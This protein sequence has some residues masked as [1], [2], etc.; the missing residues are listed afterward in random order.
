MRGSGKNVYYHYYHYYQTHHHHHHHKR[1]CATSP[2]SIE[3]KGAARTAPCL[4]VTSNLLRPNK[5]Q[6]G[7]RVNPDDANSEGKKDEIDGGTMHHGRFPSGA[8]TRRQ[9]PAARQQQHHV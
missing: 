2:S 1:M 3:L 5:A 6:P 9:L 8:L 7:Q 4:M